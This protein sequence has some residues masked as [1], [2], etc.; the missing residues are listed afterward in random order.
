MCT[1]VCDV[2]SSVVC[3]M[4]YNMEWRAAECCVGLCCVDWYVGRWGVV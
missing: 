3:S 2:V 1:V 4:E